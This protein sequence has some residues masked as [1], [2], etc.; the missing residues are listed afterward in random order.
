MFP[1]FSDDGRL[2]FSIIKQIISLVSSHIHPYHQTLLRDWYPLYVIH[3]S[4]TIHRML[5]RQATRVEHVR[6]PAVGPVHTTL[7]ADTHAAEQN[8]DGGW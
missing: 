5:T 7:V 4:C 8:L 2:V 3:R 6:Q 1:W